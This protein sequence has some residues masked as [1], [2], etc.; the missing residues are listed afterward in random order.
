MRLLR[1]LCDL[2]MT[3]D[4][5]KVAIIH[6]WL[7]GMRGGEKCLEVF[8]ELFPDATVFTLIH[9]KGS[10]S[11][12]IEKMD[13][14]TS[15]IQKLPGVSKN[16]RSFLPLFSK[17]IESFDLNGYD[18]VLSSSHCVAKGAQKMPG[19]LH[20]SYCYTP[21]RYAW[22]FFDEYF[23]S[24]NGLKKNIIKY[25]LERIK[26][27]DFA[28]NKGVDYFIAIS[29]NIK[30][31]IKEYYDR[32]ADVIY[33]PVDL[34][35][36][37]VLGFGSSVLVD[38]EYYLVVSALEPYKRVDLAI[39]SFNSSN[40]KLII[41]GRGSQLDYLK[42]IAGP[43][44]E[45]KEWV[46]DDELIKYYANCKALIFPGE[47]DFGI[48]PVEAQSYGRPVIAYSKGGALETVIPLRDNKDAPT[49]VFFD[50]QNTNSLNEA[51]G[52]FEKN[53]D[54]FEVQKIKQNAVRFARERFKHEIKDYVDEKWQ[55]HKKCQNKI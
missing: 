47:E 53:I 5:M 3:G 38:D 42:S 19:A 40:K 51:I 49:G 52:I 6:D 55:E 50:E 39:Q 43:G 2:A 14:R 41:V 37:Q 15:F 27:W 34:P 4:I 48:V 24:Q 17:A 44:I 35:N 23:S 31:R 12:T 13:I 22:K 30:D 21:I 25:L 18:L 45:L 54:L 20:V 16:Y 33:P 9:I 11:D 10:V 8:C 1:P 28:S 7:T 32:D 36:E 26:K 46:S 29:D